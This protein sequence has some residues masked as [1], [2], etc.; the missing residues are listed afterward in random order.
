MECRNVVNALSDHLD[1]LLADNDAVLIEGHLTS[2][3]PC[4]TIKLELSEIR[5]AARDLPLHTPP[6]AL[7]LR[8]SNTLEAEL[9]VEQA[10]TTAA[11]S[12]PSWWA[13]M[14]SKTFTFSLPQLAGV[15]AAALTLVVFSSVSFYRQ[16]NSVLTMRG[17]QALALLP[18]ETQLKPELDRK[19][20]TVQARMVGWQPQRRADFEQQMNRI[21]TSL[22]NCRHHLQANPND[23]L[24]LAMMRDLY[25]EK[26]QLLEDIERLKW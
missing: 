2:C 17:M 5:T 11:P 18:E 15:G 14:Q 7:W 12:K 1:G 10:A 16:Y 9:T 21:E 26:R 13:R 25:Q 22:Q 8:I 3:P 23:T 24:H 4:Q 19:L 20:Q 6:R